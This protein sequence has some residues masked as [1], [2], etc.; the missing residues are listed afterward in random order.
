[1]SGPAALSVA[2]QETKIKYDFAATNPGELSVSAGDTVMVKKYD[3]GGDGWILVERIDGKRGYIPS[4][5]VESTQKGDSEFGF[6]DKTKFIAPPA[7]RKISKAERRTKLVQKLEEMKKELVKKEKAMRDLDVFLLEDMSASESA[8][9]GDFEE[10]DSDDDEIDVDDCWPAETDAKEQKDEG[11]RSHVVAEILHTEQAYVRGLG[12]IVEQFVEPMAGKPDLFSPKTHELVFSN[13]RDIL[14]FQEKFLDALDRAIGLEPSYRSELGQVFLDNAAAFKL[15]CV[16]CANHPRATEELEAVYDNSEASRVLEACR[17]LAAARASTRGPLGSDQADTAGISLEGH[18]LTPIQRV[19]K[20]PLLLKELLKVT[21]SNHPDHAL[22]ARAVTE[23]EKVAQVINEDKRNVEELTL[24]QGSI[25]GWE[26][27]ALVETS[28]KLVYD[29]ALL[30]ISGKNFQQRHFYLFDHL[31]IYCKR[32]TGKVQLRGRLP[33]DSLQVQDLPDGEINGKPFQHGF[34][35]VNQ[36]KNKSYVVCAQSKE[37][38][39][40]WLVKIAEER[41]VVQAD[42]DAGIDRRNRERNSTSSGGGHHGPRRRTR[43]A[44]SLKQ[45]V[46]RPTLEEAQQTAQELQKEQRVAKWKPLDVHLCVSY[47]SMTWA[48]KSMELGMQSRDAIVQSILDKFNLSNVS[49]EDFR[50]V[51][52]THLGN[53]IIPADPSPHFSL[54]KEGRA[55]PPYKLFLHHRDSPIGNLR[56][57]AELDQSDA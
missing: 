39:A 4:D 3:E 42:T 5:W 45:G 22:V 23:M 17:I 29:G 27:P 44:K 36:K 37:E 18:L 49:V 9:V 34:Q 35:I 32:T 54:Q 13:I 50:L 16:Y 24:I 25:S 52:A 43:A 56:T 40:A 38:K 14:K 55:D 10:D 41:S 1:M 46:K 8:H 48:Y 7:K 33:T 6:D 53:V 15:Y 12:I 20:Y 31:L 57:V 28:S 21:P 26:G 11:R 51:Q 47:D 30:K 2:S 19:C